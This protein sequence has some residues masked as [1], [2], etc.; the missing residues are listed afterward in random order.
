MV[1]PNLSHLSAVSI[2]EAQSLVRRCVK[3]GPPG[4]SV[5]AA[6]RRASRRLDLPFSRTKNIW[7]G[8]AR[9][10]NAEEMDRLRREALNADFV[11]G[12]DALKTLSALRVT[13]SHPMF[14]ELMAAL[15]LLDSSVSAIGNGLVKLPSIDDVDANN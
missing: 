14:A 8:D 5:K 3:P 6:I 11:G 9:R 7:Y 2:T 15:R 13:H 1:A 12:I 10:I 4:E